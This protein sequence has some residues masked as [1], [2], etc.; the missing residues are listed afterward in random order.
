MIPFSGSI[1]D[2]PGDA[3]LPKALAKYPRL[4]E[5]YYDAQG[6]EIAVPLIHKNNLELLTNPA[7]YK[8]CDSDNR[9]KIE[10]TLEKAAINVL[11]KQFELA[12]V[13]ASPYLALADALILRRTELNREKGDALARLCCEMI[14]THVDDNPPTLTPDNK[15]LLLDQTEAWYRRMLIDKGPGSEASKLHLGLFLHNYR[16]ATSPAAQMEALQ[17]MGKVASKGNADAI[18]V[19]TACVSQRHFNRADTEK[20]LDYILDGAR[21]SP[22]TSL[23]AL[24][25][26]EA[27]GFIIDTDNLKKPVQPRPTPL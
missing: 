27:L 26:L 10:S 19:L 14:C 13:P 23:N 16:G 3:W 22:R 12:P 17:L 4:R 8:G 24:S 5:V 11:E 1:A 18:E 21:K 2:S 20:A 6:D 15:T 7:T 9:A 25:Q